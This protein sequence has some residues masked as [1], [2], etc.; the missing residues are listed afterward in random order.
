MQRNLLTVDDLSRDELYQMFELAAKLK[1]ERGNDNF[2]PLAGKTIGMIFAK[3][4][5][6]TRVS[7]E[8]GIHE[9]GGLEGLPQLAG[10]SHGHL[11]RQP[12]RRHQLLDRVHRV[13][14]LLVAAL[15]R[16]DR[17]HC[18]LERLDLVEGK[19]QFP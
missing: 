5:T 1:R 13:A 7:F 4:S 19:N 2:K 10:L 9:L 12:R 11:A 15:E 16:R 3:S 6:R 14:E 18:C 17:C 8:V